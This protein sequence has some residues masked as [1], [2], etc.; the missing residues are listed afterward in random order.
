MIRASEIPCESAAESAP[1][2]A[3][4]AENERIIPTTVP[5]RPVRVPRVTIVA[6]IGRF[7]VRVGISS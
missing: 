2:P 7:I 6:M 5:R 4:R 1:P 3:E